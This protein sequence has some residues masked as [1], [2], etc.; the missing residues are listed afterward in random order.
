MVV[1][2]ATAQLVAGDRAGRLDP[3][4]D[5]ALGEHVEHVVDRLGGHATEVTAYDAQHGVGAGVRVGRQRGEDGEP[6]LGHAQAHGPEQLLGSGFGD[7]MTHPLDTTTQSGMSQM[8]VG[9]VL[10][11]HV[12][13]VRWVGPGTGPPPGVRTMDP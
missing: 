7:G 13:T 9:S 5:A 12:P 11:G 1:V 10:A 3:A 6:G 4:G 2:V 8:N